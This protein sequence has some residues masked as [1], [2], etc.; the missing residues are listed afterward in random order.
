MV[1]S[2]KPPA[3]SKEERRRRRVGGVDLV[4]EPVHCSDGVDIGNIDAV[5]R[6]FIVVKRG[7]VNIHHYYIPISK[8]EGRDG[9]VLWLKV[10]ERYVKQYYERNVFPDPARYYV[11]DMPGYVTVYPELELIPSRYTRP[12]F[13]TRNRA[14]ERF[15]MHLYE[16]CKKSFGSEDDLSGHVSTSH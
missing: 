11:E 5:S 13:N 6:D 8:V 4:G 3:S 12:A 16:L 10:A 14:P 15:N 2:D 9:D 7:I 1:I